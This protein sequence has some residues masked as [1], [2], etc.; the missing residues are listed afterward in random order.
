M[1]QNMDHMNEIA[2]NILHCGLNEN[3]FNGTCI[4]K[5]AKEIWD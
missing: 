2:M 5:T 4:C 3:D 1:L